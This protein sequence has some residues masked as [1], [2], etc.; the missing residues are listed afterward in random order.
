MVVEMILIQRLRRYFGSAS[1]DATWSETSS[2]RAARYQSRQLLLP[3]SHATQL[4]L[5]LILMGLNAYNIHFV[6]S[7]MLAFC[8]VIEV[9]TALIVTYLIVCQLHHTKLYGSN[10]TL[11]LQVF[12]FI[13][14]IIVFGLLAGLSHSWQQPDCTDPYK[15][16]DSET[17][18]YTTYSGALIA[19][20]VLSSIEIILWTVTLGTTCFDRL[21]NLKSPP[22]AL[23][24]PP[25]FLH[26]ER[27]LPRNT[28][29]SHRFPLTDSWTT[30]S[31]SATVHR[32]GPQPLLPDDDYVSEN[33]HV[34]A[35]PPLRV[36]NQVS[37]HLDRPVLGTP[38]QSLTPPTTPVV[39]EVEANVHISAAPPKLPS[40]HT[41]SP[42]R[43]YKAWNPNATPRREYVPSPLV[44]EV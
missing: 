33:P 3:V 30:G 44:K 25:Q 17:A 29:T 15:S 6:V 24:A 35:P 2:D 9:C 40:I 28:D 41:R 18:S 1:S 39:H 26:I 42:P 19:S 23:T 36:T 12:M 10:V 27:P 7:G 8:L 34:L 31:W 38:S 32:S 5:A 4:I 14:W 13:S 21:S 43:A 37:A 20:S 22:G 16:I 11:V